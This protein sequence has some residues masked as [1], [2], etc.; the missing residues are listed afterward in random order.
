MI[1]VLLVDDHP[2]VRQGVAAVLEDQPSLEVVGSAGSA[3]EAVRVAIRTRPD[4][5][6]LDLEMPGADGVEAIRGLADAVP[7]ARVLV[8]TAYDADERVQRAVA[9]GAKGYLL[10]GA[11]ADE[12][13]RGIRVVYEGG[14]VLEPHVAARLL[15]RLAGR[16][17]EAVPTLSTRE[18][19]VLRLVVE[20]QANKQI[21]RALGISERTAKFH[22]ASIL[23]KLDAENRAE[24]AA[25]AVQQHLV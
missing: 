12:I 18:R 15:G 14:S 11:A 3:E 17:S 10:K 16:T 21:A 20:G 7:H 25:R 23:R 8:F 1:R 5:V 19:E 4:V 6:L 9:A 24:A 13:A 22:V 2:V